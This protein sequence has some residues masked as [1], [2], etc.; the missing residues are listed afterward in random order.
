MELETIWLFSLALFAFGLVSRGAE[1]SIVT[2]PMVFVALGFAFGSGGFGLVHVPTDSE[3]I[4]LLAEVTLVV[5]LFTDASRIDLRQLRRESALPARMLLIGLP[6]AIGLGTV[7]A[8]PLFPEFTPF[9]A[10]VLA[11]MLAPTDAALGQSVVGSPLVPKHVRQTLN[12]ESGLNDGM[13]LPALLILMSACAAGHSE[14]PA[15]W[16][17][18]GLL[19]VTLGPL[20]G[21]LVGFGGGKLTQFAVRRGWM[22]DSFQQL[23]ALA[24][25]LLA[26]SFAEQV[27]G[28]GF[29]A[30]FVAGMSLGGAASAMTSE[31]LQEFGEAE[32]QLLALL[33]FG[34]FGASLIP[35]AIAHWGW[36]DLLYAVLSL[37]V[38]RVVAIAISLI[39]SRTRP[40]LVLFLGWFGP[41]GLASVLFALLVLEEFEF[42]GADHLAAIAYL[43]VLISVFAHGITA[44][45]MA[46]ALGRSASSDGAADG[47]AGSS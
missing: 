21:I 7:V 2:P 23:A 36:I 26:F 24:L 11:A 9:A 28:N 8:I 32:G 47:A 44:F 1:R 43:T 10:A 18:F 41:R 42:R 3:V 31:R 13:A 39:G 30:A 25:A 17:R 37:T 6:L 19:Q 29:I 40:S 22:N 46:R 38:I 4:H 27:G 12:V 20:V 34:F 35:E 16:I 14:T 15:Y 33:I 5:V 45:P